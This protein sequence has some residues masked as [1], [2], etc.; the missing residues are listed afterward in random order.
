M[1]QSSTT[2]SPSS[3]S[4]AMTR[5][6]HDSQPIHDHNNS[7]HQDYWQPRRQ[8]LQQQQPQQQQQQQHTHNRNTRSSSSSS[9]RRELCCRRMKESLVNEGKYILQFIAVVSCALL[10]QSIYYYC[11]YLEN[12]S[13]R[14]SCDT[15]TSLATTNYRDHSNLSND[16]YY[17]YYLNYSLMKHIS[18]NFHKAHYSSSSITHSAC[19]NSITP[20]SVLSSTVDSMKIQYS[21]FQELLRS[22]HWLIIVLFIVSIIYLSYAIVAFSISFCR[23]VYGWWL[24]T[25]AEHNNNSN[26][27]HIHYHRH[28]YHT[29]N[30]SHTTMTTTTTRSVP[31]IQNDAGGGI[32]SVRS[33]VFDHDNNHLFFGAPGRSRHDHNDND[34]DDTNHSNNNLDAYYDDYS[35]I[36]LR[37]YRQRRKYQLHNLEKLFPIVQVGSNSNISC[38]SSLKQSTSLSS[39]SH[40]EHRRRLIEH[41]SLEEN[42]TC[43]ICLTCFMDD[44][45]VTYCHDQFDGCYHWFHKDCLFPWLHHSPYCPC[46]RKDMIPSTAS[47]ETMNSN[48]VENTG[49]ENRH[50]RDNHDNVIN[51]PNRGRHLLTDLSSFLGYYA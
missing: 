8:P 20:K 15:R 1:P 6:D 23:L 36:R 10:H 16:Y 37:Q 50:Y 3:T 42:N 14:H 28:V 47:W 30:N 35:D 22:C 26:N 21:S 5:S 41:C 12:H 29:N 24:R 43:P 2:T 27:N 40:C 45:Y 13:E 46:C 31:E 48:S 33:F 17:Y 34:H 38:C 4:L 32:I 25:Q 7:R 18:T 44:D 11:T 49:S 51:I 39:D 9:S 19:R